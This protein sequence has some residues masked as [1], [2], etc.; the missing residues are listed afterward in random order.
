MLCL[1]VR[2]NRAGRLRQKIVH[3]V[4]VASQSR[5]Y[6]IFSDAAVFVRLRDT[7]TGGIMVSYFSFTLF[8]H[9]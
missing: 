1:Q 8:Y 9:T 3:G 7:M 5:L 6:L 2:W 4:T